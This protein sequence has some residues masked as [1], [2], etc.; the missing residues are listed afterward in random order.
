MLFNEC[1]ACSWQTSVV[2]QYVA[3]PEAQMNAA[4]PLKT[5]VKDQSHL[6]WTRKSLRIQLLH[7]ML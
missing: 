7:Y 3:V 1:F 5:S 4:N 2:G 6:K